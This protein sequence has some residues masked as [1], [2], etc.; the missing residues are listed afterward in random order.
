[1]ENEKNVQLPI[2]SLSIINAK[3]LNYRELKYKKR[4][5]FDTAWIINFKSVHIGT[6]WLYP[7]ILFSHE[8]LMTTIA[9]DR[10]H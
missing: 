6:Q 9:T 10:Y 3:F 4:R 2:M 5:G 1:M 8:L 7:I